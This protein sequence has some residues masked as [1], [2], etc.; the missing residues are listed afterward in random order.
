V[1]VSFIGGMKP[2]YPE[3]NTDLQ[4]VTVSC[5]LQMMWMLEN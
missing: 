4:Q 2:E 5:G 3:K 1:A